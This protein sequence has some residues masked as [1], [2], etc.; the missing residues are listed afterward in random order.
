MF[1]E[2][3]CHV[4][5]AVFVADE[6]AGEHH[7]LVDGIIILDGVPFTFCGQVEDGDLGFF[8]F[9]AGAEVEGEIGCVSDACPCCV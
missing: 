2:W 4:G 7:T 3:A 9:N 5:D 6:S 1:V 8:D